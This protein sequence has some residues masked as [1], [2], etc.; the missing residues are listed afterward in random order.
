MQDAVELMIAGLTSRGIDAERAGDLARA[1]LDPHEALWLVLGPEGQVESISRQ[2]S[3]SN[4][5]VELVTAQPGAVVFMLSAEHAART[6]FAFAPAGAPEEA[7]PGDVSERPWRNPLE[8]HGHDYSRRADHAAQWL[9]SIDNLLKNIDEV[10]NLPDPAKR[11]VSKDTYRAAGRRGL[12]K[13]A[14]TEAQIAAL[15]DDLRDFPELLR[16]APPGQTEVGA[17]P[18]SFAAKWRSMIQSRKDKLAK[19]REKAEEFARQ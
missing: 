10:L 11:S 15:E 5:C 8:I 6:G 4:R 1:T 18:S 9:P 17:K 7:E 3:S 14:Q 12:E 16:T 13:V 2:D 19:L